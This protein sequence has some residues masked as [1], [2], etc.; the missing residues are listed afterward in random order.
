[1]KN[2]DQFHPVA[3]LLYFSWAR[4]C[5]PNSNWLLQGSD[6][7]ERRRKLINWTGLKKLMLQ[8][9]T[10]HTA[11]MGPV[12][13][14]TWIN[15]LHF[16][17]CDKL[18]IKFLPSGH[19]SRYLVPHLSPNVKCEVFCCQMLTSLRWAAVGQQ[20]LMCSHVAQVDLVKL[21]NIDHDLKWFQC[22]YFS[23]AASALVVCIPA[24]IPMKPKGKHIYKNP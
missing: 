4:R 2:L 6:R 20:H 21:A 3:V 23:S 15:P 16:S 14:V 13:S 18:T 24:N 1:M 17:H 10:L 19:I 11:C 5:T 22:V 7:A 9:S 12:D 8:Y